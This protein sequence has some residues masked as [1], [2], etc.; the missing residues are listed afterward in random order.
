MEI[1]IPLYPHP[2]ASPHPRQHDP[3]ARGPRGLATRVT[4]RFSEE[5]G[6]HTAHFA[7]SMTYGYPSP[8][9]GKRSLGIMPSCREANMY[10]EILY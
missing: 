8:F 7:H 4:F 6:D 9:I 5:D 2:S 3:D 10:I 1:T